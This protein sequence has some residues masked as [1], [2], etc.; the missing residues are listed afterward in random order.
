MSFK[1]TLAGA[2]PFAHL[3]SNGRAAKAE[4]DERKQREGESD[5]DYAT[6]MEELDEKEREEEEA[7]RAEKERE[8]EEARRAAAE[9]GED[10]DDETDDAKKAS[11]ATER[12]RCA[13]IMAHGI[14]IGQPAQAGVFAFDT[15]MS[16]KVAIAA[17]DAGQ[18]AAPQ[19]RRAS[20]RMSLGDRM[21]STTIPNPGA[22]AVAAGAPSLADQIVA[23]GKKRRG[24]A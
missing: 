23:A 20:G 17:L 3:L 14:S 19:S 10:G 12:A 11:R 18:A 22:S 24:E 7:R 6:R 2:M 8:E 4:D 5:E 9:D 1:K 16:S 21:G 13:R 15:K